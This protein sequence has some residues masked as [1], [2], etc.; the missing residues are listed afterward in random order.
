MKMDL[1]NTKGMIFA[2]WEF[3]LSGWDSSASAL[4]GIK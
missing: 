2:L 3:Q 4:Q 1:K